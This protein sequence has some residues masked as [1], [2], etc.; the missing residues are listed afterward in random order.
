LTNPVY[1]RPL[2]RYMRYNGDTISL[3]HDSILH[4]NGTFILKTR[5][6]TRRYVH[7]S[8]C[9][10]YRP[11]VNISPQK[12]VFIRVSKCLTAICELE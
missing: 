1:E 3:R 2:R 5:R 4:S 9:C 11:V 7:D 8:V 10:V 12:A 6:Y